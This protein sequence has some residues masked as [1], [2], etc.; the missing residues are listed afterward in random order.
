LEDQIEA[1]DDREPMLKVLADARGSFAISVGSL[2][3]YLIT[4]KEAFKDRFDENWIINSNAYLTIDEEIDSLNEEQLALWQQ[5][6]T[7]REQFAV[8]SIKMFEDRLSEKWNIANHMLEHDI[9]PDIK[10]ITA[11]LTDMTQRQ[12]KK[13]SVEVKSLGD[14]L[15]RVKIVSPIP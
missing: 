15:A 10:K 2:R 7:L 12:N 14:I 9:E 11:L 3:A 1:D 4:G 5:Y 13:V 6:E 8:M